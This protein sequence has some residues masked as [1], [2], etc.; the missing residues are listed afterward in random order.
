[1]KADLGKTF[2]V[3]GA[4][5]FIGSYLVEALA[6][7]GCDVRAI[8]DLS[9]GSRPHFDSLRD[10]SNVSLYE[11]DVCAPSALEKAI[12]GVDGVFHLAAVKHNPSKVGAPARLI[13]TN[14]GGTLNV[15][16][17]ARQVG[18]PRVVFASSL[19]VYGIEQKT[20]FREQDP[21]VT[22]TLYGASK[23]A[24]ESLMS[25]YRFQYGIESVVL[26]YFFVYGPRLYR[27]RYKYAFVAGTLDRL[28]QGRPP[29]V[30]G[31]GL[32]TFDYIFIDDAVQATMLA[33]DKAPSGTVLNVGTG[34]ETRILDLCRLLS[35]ETGSALEPEFGP[36]DE[37][38]DTVRVADNS[39]MRRV[40]GFEPEIDVEEGVRRI[41]A[42]RL[43]DRSR[44]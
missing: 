14:V 32:Q 6:R 2:A 23:V 28:E 39:E 27:G 9:S 13:E 24:G 38:F 35:K 18:V 12:D 15:L 3:T 11:V 41:V 30:Y 36:A 1:M 34:R 20:P 26:R 16:E 42:A 31:D 17:A 22:H 25:A 43:E 44:E 5:G 19:Y 33:M 37:T 21:L 4:A 40:L 29:L 10:H 8:D 7:Q